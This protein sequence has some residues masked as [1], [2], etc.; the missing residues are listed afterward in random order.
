MGSRCFIARS[1]IR[2]RSVKKAALRQDE[3][4]VRL[5]ALHPLERAI[6][7]RGVSDLDDVVLDTER[8]RRVRRELHLAQAPRAL[9]REDGDAP[10]S[11]EGGLDD[12]QPLSRQLGGGERHT[13]DV[14]PGARQARHPA[15]VDRII[16]RERHDDGDRPSRCPRRRDR[17]AADEEHVDTEADQ[18]RR[19]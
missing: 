1:A 16:D 6:V 5:L 13:C 3:E 9:P 18:L 17:L 19:K 10:N 14:A 15:L 8:T 7:L 11:R 2:R 12:L 4:R